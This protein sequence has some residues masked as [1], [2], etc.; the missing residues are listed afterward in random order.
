MPASY[1]REEF[2]PLRSDIAGMREQDP[3]SAVNQEALTRLQETFKTNDI[4]N[5]VG[6]LDVLGARCGFSEEGI[7]ND[8]LRLHSMAHELINDGCGTW[9]EEPGETIYELAEDLLDDIGDWLVVLRQIEKMLD[10][11]VELRP[12]EEES[13]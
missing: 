4:L 11:L 10:K 7:R 8:F 2:R 9:P 1:V 13:F 12:E 6:L 3:E 5:A